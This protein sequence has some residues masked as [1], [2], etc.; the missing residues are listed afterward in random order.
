VSALVFVLVFVLGVLSV[1]RSITA[2][3]LE[4]VGVRDI[5]SIDRNQTAGLIFD[6]TYRSFHHTS[7]F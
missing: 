3:V 5:S 6:G 1:I 2:M 4:S 7:L